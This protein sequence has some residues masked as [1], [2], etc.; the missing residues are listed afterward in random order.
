[1]KE[2]APF[3]R[4]YSSIS[5]F[6][7]THN[8]GTSLVNLQRHIMYLRYS[9]ITKMICPYFPEAMSEL[10]SFR[11]RWYD[12]DLY[13]SIQ[14]LERRLERSY[15]RSFPNYQIHRSTRQ[16]SC[17]SLIAQSDIKTGLQDSDEILRNIRDL[18]VSHGRRFRASLSVM[19][20]RGDALKLASTLYNDLLNI[21]V[22][23]KETEQGLGRVLV[24][25]IKILIDLLFQHGPNQGKHWKSWI[26]ADLFH[27]I[28][29]EVLLAS[30]KSQNDH[31]HDWLSRV[32]EGYLSF[33]FTKKIL[34][35][36]DN[37]V[38]NVPLFQNGVRSLFGVFNDFL[39]CRLIPVQ[40][41]ERSAR[42]LREKLD[43]IQGLT[44]GKITRLDIHLYF[45][46]EYMGLRLAKN[47]KTN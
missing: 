31:S 9:G 39:S 19:F 25:I 40:T 14:R 7:E 5:Q 45:F 43:I 20:V 22:I 35:L 13:N 15:E 26:P 29:N 23:V 21:P 6:R 17:V 4:A 47:G 37:R 2:L 18:N 3:T 41:S 8:I 30:I 36:E 46:E 1:M 34:V 24:V 28:R 12:D 44:S 10:P 33:R 11:D 32:D 27:K 16:V 42:G 38:E